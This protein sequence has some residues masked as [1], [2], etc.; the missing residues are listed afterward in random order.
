[1]TT[2]RDELMNPT[3]PPPAPPVNDAA[4]NR[5]P[6]PLAPGGPRASHPIWAFVSACAGCHY[7]I[8]LIHPH[9]AVMHIA[10]EPAQH[11][12]VTIRGATTTGRI[13]ADCRPR[14]QAAGEHRMNGS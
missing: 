8:Y 1:M 4:A 11:G 7:P 10:L 14:P 5:L 6:T 2:L 9:I 13:H 3:S 12:G